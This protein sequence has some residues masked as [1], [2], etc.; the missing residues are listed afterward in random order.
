MLTFLTKLYRLYCFYSS[1]AKLIIR[2]TIKNFFLPLPVCSSVIEIGGGNAMMRTVLSQ[3]CRAEKYISSDIAPTDQTDV[4][5]DAQNMIFSDEQA[6]VIAAFEVIE[7]IP[8]TNKFLS[9]VW[10]VLRTNG[11]LVLSFPFLYGRHD[12]QDFY[13]WTPQG[14]Q[15]I[16]KLHGLTL[17]LI[18]NRGGTFLTMV[19]LL[20]NFIH[21]FFQPAIGSWRAQGIWKKMYFGIMT[22]VMFPVMLLSWFAFGIDLIIDRNSSNPSGYVIIAQKMMDM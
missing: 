13:R 21:S 4:V 1:P 11:Y 17:V 8:D 5:C 7:H 2:R 6:D 16:L 14:I 3:A 20:S 19:T 18:K 15:R 10:R 9:E 22:I 12:F